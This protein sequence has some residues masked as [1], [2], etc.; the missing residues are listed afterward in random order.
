M[1]FALLSGEVGSS[2]LQTII[3][4]VGDMIAFGGTVLDKAIQNPIMLGIMAAGFIGIGAAV[5]GKLI[6]V[7]R[8]IG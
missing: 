7:A 5:V 1:N 3:G 6:G 4:G 2:S 8:T